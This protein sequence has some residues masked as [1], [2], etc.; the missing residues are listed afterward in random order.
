MLGASS[1]QTNRE[2]V[3]DI[4]A[5]CPYCKKVFKVDLSPG[6]KANT[7]LIP[8]YPCWDQFENNPI[9]IPTDLLFANSKDEAEKELRKLWLE[10]DIPEPNFRYYKKFIEKNF[11]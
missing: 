7:T 6:T 5:A 2:I 3:W 11:R 4:Q 8:C 9:P 10:L 1:R